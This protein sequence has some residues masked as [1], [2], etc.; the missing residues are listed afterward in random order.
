MSS[1]LDNLM[2]SGAQSFNAKVTLSGTTITVGS[3]DGS[4]Y[5]LINPLLIRFDSVL[6]CEHTGGNPSLN[7]GTQTFGTP[8]N[9]GVWDGYVGLLRSSASVAVLTFSLSATTGIVTTKLNAQAYDTYSGGTHT[10]KVALVAR[11][12]NMKRSNSGWDTSTAWVE[13]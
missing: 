6:V 1:F 11:I 9:D 10:G 13:E 4:Q 2:R 5:S 12:R 8:A 7:F 3:Y